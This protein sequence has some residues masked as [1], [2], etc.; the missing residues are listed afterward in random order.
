MTMEVSGN[1]ERVEQI[2]R[3]KGIVLSSR[4]R[5]YTREE[6]LKIVQEEALYSRKRIAFDTFCS[7][8]MAV[9]NKEGDA[10]RLI[11]TDEKGMHIE[12]EVFQNIEEAYG[13]MITRLRLY[14]DI[15]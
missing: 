2:L 11:I 4:D 3:E 12:D 9:I 13:M 5:R 6:F 7:D 8:N 1:H 15:C 10:Y 14:T